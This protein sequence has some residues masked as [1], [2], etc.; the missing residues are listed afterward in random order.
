MIFVDADGRFTG[1]SKET[2]QETLIIA[3]HAVARGNHKE[4]INEGFNRY[5]N[6]VHKINSADKGNLQQRLQG[7]LFAL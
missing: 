3:V 2:F 1:M 4:N 6:K 7:V 5:F